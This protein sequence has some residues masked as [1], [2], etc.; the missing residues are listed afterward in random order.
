MRHQSFS[1][2][3]NHSALFNREMTDHS[4]E[5]GLETGNS[6][7][8]I[9]SGTATAD[10]K[11]FQRESTNSRENGFLFKIRH[12]TEFR[13]RFMHTAF[14]WWGFVTLVR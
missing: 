4:E 11:S 13:L 1:I 7:H 14:V 2:S 8:H 5:N 9:I 10:E 6:V 3:R 12:E